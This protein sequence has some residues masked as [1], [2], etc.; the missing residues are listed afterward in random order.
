MEGLKQNG[1]IVINSPSKQA[2]IGKAYYVDANKIAK[3]LGLIV[4]GWPV[5]NTILMGAIAKV[6]SLITK[7]A[8]VDSINETFK[9]RIAEL[10]V[11]GAERGFSEVSVLG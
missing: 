3:E 10:N 8:L 5:V 11:Q 2:S 6:T 4:A 1:T 7:D 9:G